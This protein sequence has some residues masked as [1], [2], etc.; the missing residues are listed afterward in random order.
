MFVG[1][2]VLILPVRWILAGMQRLD[3]NQREQNAVLIVVILAYV[4]LAWFIT[5]ALHR[6]M[7][8]TTNRAIRLGI[9]VAATVLAV[10]T[11]WLWSNPGGVLASL[12]G[13][14]SSRLSMG[15]DAVW[16][17]GRYPDSETLRRLKRENITAVIS[18]EHPGDLVE[19]QGIEE[20][21]R[22]TRELGMQLIEAPMLP[23]VSNNEASLNLIR[24]IARKAP[25]DTT[26]TVGWAET[27]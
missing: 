14:T 1:T 9:P 25:A 8:T 3:W 22:A 24:S 4:V 23:W 2:I 27:G 20:E 21:R 16:E 6:R 19:R 11:F 13:G 12:A 7:L 15:S 17:F 18:L 5:R 26:C 10:V